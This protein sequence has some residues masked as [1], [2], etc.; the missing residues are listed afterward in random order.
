VFSQ[1]DIRL[2]LELLT[3]KAFK[4][5]NQSL[6]FMTPDSVNYIISRVI[7]RKFNQND[8]KILDVN[9]GTSNLLQ[10]IA[11]H[12]PNETELFGIESNKDV[13]QLASAWADLQNN[14]I[15]IYL[16]DAIYPIFDLVDVQISDL[17]CYEY[18]KELLSMHPL[19][20]TNITYF[21]YLAILGKLD[22]LKDQG[23]FFYVINN[24]FFTNSQFPMFQTYI[25]EFATLVG[26]IV[27]PESMFRQE[28][29]QKSILIGKKSIMVSHHLMLFPIKNLMKEQL[30]E[31]F[32]KL[33]QF[34]D[35]L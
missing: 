3:I 5:T 14:E 8:L 4:D 2:A 21:P 13:V 9:L 24:D 22:N 15:K 34:T 30:P 31:L 10:A 23:Y 28:K 11:N 17:D 16:Q 7:N 12:Y 26:L 19:K 33:D 18:E 20:H 25:K 35:K 27:L 29:Q 1:E 32:A 6:D